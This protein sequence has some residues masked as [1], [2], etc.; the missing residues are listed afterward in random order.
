MPQLAMSINKN[1]TWEDFFSLAAEVRCRWALAKFCPS[2]NMTQFIEAKKASEYSFFLLCFSPLHRHIV[3]KICVTIYP[4]TGLALARAGKP[5]TD[6]SGQW[7][8]RVGGKVSFLLV[9][10]WTLIKRFFYCS[11][12]DYM[13]LRAC[14]AVISVARNQFMSLSRSCMRLLM[15]VAGWPDWMRSN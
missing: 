4:R 9:D 14:M 8:G 11:C 2:P 13:L 6:G 15:T 5:R 7:Q 12:V 1:T 10:S 3:N